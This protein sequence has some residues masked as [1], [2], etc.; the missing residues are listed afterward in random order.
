LRAEVE[1]EF[2]DE[3]EAKAIAEAVS[4]DNLEAPEG[5]KVETWFEG[6]KLYTV[7]ECRRGVESLVATLDDLLACVHSAEKA[8]EA[9]RGFKGGV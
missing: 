3:L 1:I 5:L 2:R 6:H 7:I 8:I 4:P 9:L